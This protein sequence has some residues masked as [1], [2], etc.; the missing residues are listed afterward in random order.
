MKPQSS[1]SLQNGHKALQATKELPTQQIAGMRFALAT[2]IDAAK[3]VIDAA[4]RHSAMHV[5]LA[6]AYTVSLA[7]TD[8]N[9]RKILN[10]GLVFP[11]GK[12]ITWFSRIFRQQPALSQ[13][14]GPQLF[15]DVLKLGRE[16]DL[17]HF[18]LGSTPATIELMKARI[19]QDYPGVNI[20]GGY[21]PPFRTLTP[22][23]LSQQDELIKSLKPDIVWV[24]LGTP[25]QDFEAERIA[26]QLDLAAV[27][28]G[29]AFD[30]SAGTLK[31]A[32]TWM[33]IVGLEWLFRFG[34]EPRR[35]WRRYLFGN[36]QFLVSAVRHFSRD[37]PRMFS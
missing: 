17:R 20:V 6:N 21:S 31:I 29:A 26:N 36:I 27:A 15:L 12:P 11:D 16:Q 24:G 25:K 5:H 4:L 37:S 35:L 28:V 8:E 10:S 19:G 13:V 7:D 22:T 34:S 1:P 23:E 32:P 30:F 3:Y 2:P 14:R 18:F 9:Y 33:Q